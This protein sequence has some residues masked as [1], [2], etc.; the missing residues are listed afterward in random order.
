M[1]SSVLK[2]KCEVQRV[3]TIRAEDGG[4]SV[5]RGCYHRQEVFGSWRL[6][7]PL[8]ADSEQE[9]AECLAAAVNNAP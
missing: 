5:R 4:V 6:F 3:E 9:V 7:V 8:G 2:E 1:A